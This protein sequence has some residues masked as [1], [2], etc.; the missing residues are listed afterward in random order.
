MMTDQLIRRID[1]KTGEAEWHTLHE[2]NVINGYEAVSGDLLTTP[3][4]IAAAHNPAPIV[5]ARQTIRQDKPF[6]SVH[7][8]L[9]AILAPQAQADVYRHNPAPTSRAKPN[10]EQRP[11]RDDSRDYEC[12]SQ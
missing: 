9:R 3:D 7:N 11:R 5:P 4:E 8:L 10:G 12:D 2:W 1:G 6:P